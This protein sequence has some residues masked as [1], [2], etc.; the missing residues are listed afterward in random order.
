MS[1]IMINSDCPVDGDL[2]LPNDDFPPSCVHMT[3][4]DD[5]NF[6]E[7]QNSS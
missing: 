1:M 7:R 5:G 2:L 6:D 4:P 3:H